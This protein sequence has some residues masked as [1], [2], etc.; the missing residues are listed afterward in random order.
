MTLSC[1]KCQ[2]KSVH[3][4]IYSNVSIHVHDKYCLDTCH[5]FDLLTF[6]GLKFKFS[7]YVSSL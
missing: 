6:N 1:D 2:L 3:E 4:D 7:T 5:V